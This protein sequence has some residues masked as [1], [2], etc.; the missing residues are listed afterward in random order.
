[1]TSVPLEA[2]KPELVEPTVGALV[3][4]SFYFIANSQRDLYGPDGKL[5]A[6]AQPKP[7]EIY[8]VPADMGMDTLPPAQITRPRTPDQ[9]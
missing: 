2:N 6:G 3:G 4:D 7:R 9:G 5:M 1:M 8:E